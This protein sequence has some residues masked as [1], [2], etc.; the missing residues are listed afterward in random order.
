M[1]LCSAN[2]SDAGIINVNSGT[3]GA[4]I[5]GNQNFLFLSL[6]RADSKALSVAT[7]KPAGDERAVAMLGKVTCDVELSRSIME[8][9]CH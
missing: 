3:S 5:G 9:L 1:T 6:S 4:E 2:G 8:M 7:K